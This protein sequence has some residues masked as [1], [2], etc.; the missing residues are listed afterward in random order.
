MRVLR[1]ACLAS[2]LLV[3]G[4]GLGLAQEKAE[5][6]H[7]W[8]SGGE[9][10]SVKVF[11]DAFT[12][13]G[14]T[15]IDTAI[16]GGVNA[17]TAGINRIVG[18]NPPT[19]MQFNTGKQFDELVANGLL[20][21]LTP[22]AEAGKWREVLPPG[23]YNAITRNGRVYAV[24]VNIH[25][26]HWLFYNK[27]VFEKA[28]LQPPKT[29]PEVLE[30]GKKL[31]EKGVI[32]LA[33]PGQPN[34]ERGVFN[35]VLSSYGGPELF[36][37]VYGERSQKAIESPEFTKVVELFASLRQLA[38][39]GSPG[40]NWNDSAA[41]VITG[42]AAM[43]TM[44]DWAK[45]EFIAAGQ[46]A[47]KEFGC[48]LLGEKAPIVMGGDVF[49][50][51][52]TNDPAAQAAQDKLA[53][54]MFSPEVQ[55]AFNQ[56]KGSLPVRLDVDVSKMDVC[57]QAGKEALDKPER[58]VEAQELLSPP[59]LTGAVQDVITQFWNNPSAKTEE[60]VQDFAD[61]VQT[62]G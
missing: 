61:A 20:R 26:Q 10:A 24:P 7:W 39:P 44:G 55:I 9:S 60:F 15:W 17:R 45:G 37:Q 18:G 56:K 6:I 23:I 22:L 58:Q 48:V 3:A 21:D 1:Q 33:I 31:K 32:A 34:W 30:F 8:T 36:R 27:G 47:G 38:D 40:R 28:G 57:A 43:H 12:K 19:M 51:P 62:A 5:V 4:S 25:G 41:L 59:D 2:A 42:K 14:G 11:A 46:T 53:K 29:W 54:L 52:K 49:V 16:A 13:A 35:A 50:F